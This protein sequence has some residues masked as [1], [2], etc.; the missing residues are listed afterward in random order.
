MAERGKETLRFGP[1]KPVGLT[2]N[3]NLNEKPY[4]VVQLR[5]ENKNKSLFNIVGFQTKMKYEEQVRIF[6]T[7]PGL[8]NV[9]FARLGGIHRNTYINSPKILNSKLQ[10]KSKPNIRFAGQISGV[11]GYV[12]SAAIGMVCAIFVNA[13]LKGKK[14][15]DIPSVTSTGSLLNYIRNGSET[16][17]FQPMNVNFGLFPD[18]DE[19]I[20]GRKNRKYR[21]QQYTQRAKDA[22]LN[23]IKSYKKN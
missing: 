4:A 3:N 22:W 7:I 6:R 11:E 18:L 8:E 2:N 19:N 17:N 10:L 23:W 21:Y 13:E 14:L 16:N 20:K 1:M 15:K 5:F 12:E 9:R